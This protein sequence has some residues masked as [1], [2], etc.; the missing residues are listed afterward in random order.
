MPRSSIELRSPATLPAGFAGSAS[1]G[2]LVKADRPSNLR[3]GLDCFDDGD[4]SVPVGKCWVVD[5]GAADRQ[6]DI[7]DEIAEG[8]AE[9]LGVTGR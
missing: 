1:K 5:V 9:T 8:I 7:A 6:V 2:I 3:T 4:Q